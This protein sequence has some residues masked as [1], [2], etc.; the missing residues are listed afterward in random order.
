VE[1]RL[2]VKWFD[3]GEIKDRDKLYTEEILFVRDYIDEQRIEK[4]HSNMSI[5]DSELVCISEYCTICTIDRKV[6]QNHFRQNDLFCKLR[7]Q[8]AIYDSTPKLVEF[9]NNVKL[10]I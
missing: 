7:I 8:E 5:L 1:G 6:Y 4:L 2:S 9:G 3:L 10:K